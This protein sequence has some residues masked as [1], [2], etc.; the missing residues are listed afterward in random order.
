MSIKTLHLKLNR[1][2]VIK[3][4]RDL[5]GNESDRLSRT[6]LSANEYN[7]D[8]ANRNCQCQSQSVLRVMYI[9]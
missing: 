2:P 8:R 3:K 4:D 9:K 7:Y 5:L 6:C 1:F